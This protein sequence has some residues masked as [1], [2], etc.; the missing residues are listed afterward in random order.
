MQLRTDERV[1]GFI[2][3]DAVQLPGSTKIMALDEVLVEIEKDEHY[4]IA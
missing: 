1:V 4:E 3:V 2:D